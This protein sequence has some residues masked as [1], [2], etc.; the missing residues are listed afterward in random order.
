MRVERL[1][2]LGEITSIRRF[3]S[4][5]M[6]F[7]SSGRWTHMMLARGIGA[8]KVGALSDRSAGI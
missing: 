7:G 3:L 5:K 2:S 1:G 6:V 4:K 8:G